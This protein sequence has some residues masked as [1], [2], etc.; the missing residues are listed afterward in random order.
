MYSE[1]NNNIAATILWRFKDPINVKDIPLFLFSEWVAVNICKELNKI[2]NEDK[3]TI[4][5]PNDIVINNKKICGILIENVIM[6]NEI[7]ALVAGFGININQINFPD[8]IPNATSLKLL[9]NKDYDVYEIVMSIFNSL[10]DTTNFIFYD[11]E[12]IHQEYKKM[13]LK[14]NIV[15]GLLLES[16]EKLRVQIMDIL[17][18]GAIIVK[19]FNNNMINKFY[20]H[21]FRVIY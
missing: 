3:F 7:H 2:L 18:D 8:D 12:T 17:E 4:K 9:T 16:R 6:G 5:W 11:G 15:D 14:I 1:A 20:H 10:I 21:Q 19:N 13:A